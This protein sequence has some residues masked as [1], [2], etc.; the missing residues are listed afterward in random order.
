MPVT[1]K[2]PEPLIVALLEPV[3]LP[4]TFI[5]PLSVIMVLLLMLTFP[6]LTK[7]P[8]AL[9]TIMAL[10]LKTALP[11]VRVAPL[12]TVMVALLLTVKAP[13]K[14]VLPL[15]VM[16][17]L[18]DAV[19]ETA[20]P[21]LIKVP[22]TKSVP[23]LDMLTLALAVTLLLTVIFALPPGTAFV[24]H[25]LLVFQLPLATE[26]TVCAVV[27]SVANKAIAKA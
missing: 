22:L 25:V 18:L 12:F 17:V 3:T 14:V 19:S 20:L 6:L 4:L 15:M 11:T 9:T 2:L 10:L 26:L 27:A 13:K 24:L 1:C 23:E 7:V 5:V 21:E 8:P 16:F